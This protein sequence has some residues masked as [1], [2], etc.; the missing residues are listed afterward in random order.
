MA[1]KKV[2][3]NL[4]VTSLEDLESFTTYVRSRS[5]DLEDAKRDAALGKI[6][7][8]FFIPS[9][10][11]YCRAY[12]KSIE[13]QIFSRPDDMDLSFHDPLYDDGQLFKISDVTYSIENMF[14]PRLRRILRSVTKGAGS[15]YEVKFEVDGSLETVIVSTDA[16]AILSCLLEQSNKDTDWVKASEIISSANV[17]VAQL[18]DAFTAIDAKR[19]FEL[20]VESHPEKKGFYRLR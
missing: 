1:N 13:N 9:K 18:K 6:V 20:T 3:N 15:N 4:S 17:R 10:N 14:V 2:A 12:A 8:Y 7:V 5:L 11:A 19:I 16:G